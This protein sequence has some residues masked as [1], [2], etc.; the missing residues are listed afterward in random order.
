MTEPGPQELCAVR[1]WE[2]RTRAG[3]G[4]RSQPAWQTSDLNPGRG[5]AQRNTK[6]RLSEKNYTQITEA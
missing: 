2:E 1:H 3:P 6:G 4:V 5:G